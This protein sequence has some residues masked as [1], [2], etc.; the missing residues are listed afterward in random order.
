MAEPLIGGKERQR[1]RIID[2]GLHAVGVQVR[3]QRVAARMPDRVE[4]IDVGAVGRDLRHR[5]ILD[6]VE[7]GI[8]DFRGVLPRFRPLGQV[9]QFRRQ[10]RRLH[11]VEPAVD[12]LDMML[13][14]HQHHIEGINSR[15]TAAICLSAAHVPARGPKRGRT[16]RKSTMPGLGSRMSRCRRS[17]PK[18]PRLSP[19]HHQASAPRRA[20]LA[21][22]NANGVQT[23]INYPR[24]AVPRRLSAI[25]PSSFRMHPAI[26]K[27]YSL[28]CSARSRAS[29]RTRSSIWSVTLRLAV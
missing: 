4:M 17:R 13:V 21:P 10:D 11:A 16:P 3:S 2:R 7:A 29:S 22:L 23:A 12:A 19:L 27:C 8:V 1:G 9:R 24:A 26:R 6:L 18:R 15:W 25:V 14:L 5:D 20:C 28:R